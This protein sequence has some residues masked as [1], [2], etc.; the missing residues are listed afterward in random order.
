MPSE[1]TLI[2]FQTAALGVLSGCNLTLPDPENLP[3]AKDDWALV[4]GGSSNVGRFGIQLF[5]TCGYRVIASCST[6]SAEVSFP[7]SLMSGFYV[8]M[9]PTSLPKP[10]GRTLC[11]TINN[12]SLNKSA[13]SSL[14][15]TTPKRISSMF[16]MQLPQVMSW[17]AS[18]SKSF[19]RSTGTLL[20]PM[21]GRYFLSDPWQMAASPDDNLFL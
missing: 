1:D 20:Q 8:N 13:T 9:S 16:L 11:L 3:S 15:S 2:R 5:K 10:A 18:F 19:Q 7:E 6:Q 14:L 17:H 12:R 21:T 4:L